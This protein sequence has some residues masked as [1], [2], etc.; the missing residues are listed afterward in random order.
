MSKTIELF[1]GTASFSKVAEE[2]GHS[3][4]TIDSD[5][6]HDPMLCVD[7]SEMERLPEKYDLI[8][9]SPPCQAFSVASIGT[10]WTGGKGAYKAKSIKAVMALALLK[11]TIKLIADAKPKRWYI[12]N[13]RGVM[14]KVIEPMLEKRGLSFRRVTIS[15]CQYGDKRMKPTDI[16]TN[17]L[18]WKPRPM[19]KNGD[20]CHEAAPRGAKTGTQGLKGAKERG[21]IPP[22]LFRE[23]FEAHD[24]K[25]TNPQ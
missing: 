6:S 20:P 5:A 23:I 21:V 19:C 18:L 13:P 7:I 12:E 2:L 10:H 22:A 3:V 25:E 24:G 1:S 8:W 4:M 11:H 17:D 14:R 15:Y 9:A 16:W